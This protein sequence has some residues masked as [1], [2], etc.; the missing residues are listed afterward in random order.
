MNELPFKLEKQYSLVTK[1]IIEKLWSDGYVNIGKMFTN[2][3]IK[4]IKKIFD[5]L[6]QNPKSYNDIK[7]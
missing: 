1:N 4:T 2:N 5:P 6:L 3:E 7:K